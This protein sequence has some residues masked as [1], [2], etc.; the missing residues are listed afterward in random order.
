MPSAQIIRASGPAVKIGTDMATAAA[1]KEPLVLVLFGATGD[2]SGLKI[3]P[4]L[5]ALWQRK[6]MPEK[7]AVVG[8][9]IEKYSDDQFRDLARKAVQ[10]HGRLKPA[11]DE[12][13]KQFAQLLSYQAVDF[14]DTASYDSLGERITK[15]ETERQLPGNRLF[16]LAISPTFFATVIDQLSAQRL[17]HRYR[18]GDAVVSGG[19]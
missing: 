15:I 12:E 19:D 1:A 9:A 14:S 6:F 5:F 3:L 11:N 4:A 8:V 18:P 10:D 16:Y 7:I 13:W 2:L 17:M